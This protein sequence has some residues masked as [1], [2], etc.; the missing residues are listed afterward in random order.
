M[1]IVQTM[2]STSMPSSCALPQGFL[3]AGIMVS[4][5][6]LGE[7]NVAAGRLDA[8]EQAFIEVCCR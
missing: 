5:E 1:I 4:L 2:P 6:G 7:A 8:A 3:R